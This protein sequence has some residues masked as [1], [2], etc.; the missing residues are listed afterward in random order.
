MAERGGVSPPLSVVWESI[1]TPRVVR[2]TCSLFAIHLGKACRCEKW[3]W[4]CRSRGQEGCIEAGFRVS[5]DFAG[6]LPLIAPCKA[7]LLGPL[8]RLENRCRQTGNVSWWCQSKVVNLGL[9]K[10]ITVLHKASSNPSPD[11]GSFRTPLCHTVFSEFPR[12]TA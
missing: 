9:L 8:Y 4:G 7:F 12:S 11:L 6:P 5:L 2:R 10:C 1:T 3:G